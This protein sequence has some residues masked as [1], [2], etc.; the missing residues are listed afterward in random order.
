MDGTH[1][2]PAPDLRAR[3]AAEGHDYA[4]FQAVD[5]LLRESGADV[6]E[7]ALFRQISDDLIFRVAADLGFP[8]SDVVS[9]APVRLED[10]T[11]A[12]PL[13]MTVSFL[14]LHG[15]SSPLP[16]HMLESAV[17]SAGE[18][19]VQIAFNDFFSNRL[20]WLFYLIW[21]KYRYDVRY[22]PGA[23]DQFSAWMFSL[24]GIGFP[25]MRGQADIPWARL[26][27]YLGA[28]AGRVRS[29]EMVAG[30]IAHAFGLRDVALREFDLRVVTIPE[31]QRA[32]VGQANVRL[33]QDMVI[34]STVRDRRGK[35]RIVLSGLSFERFRDFLPSGKDFP[36]L[37][38]LVAFLLKDRLAWDLELT[39]ERNEVPALELGVPRRA[40]LGW[41]TFIGNT[42]T[43][44]LKPVVMRAQ[45]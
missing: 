6:E 39:L 4:F 2:Q 29:P 5:L 11:E 17:W 33:G 10:G 21:R 45:A 41:T 7:R 43:E 28:V 15:T 25:Q 8:A 37:K 23:S 26:L 20:I 13:E 12:G 16:S 27:T 34:G 9:V 22:R 35:F 42:E 3:L 32:R 40:S 1:R 31:D 14:G 36:R 18:E 38:E 19:G 24:I 44:G 30:V